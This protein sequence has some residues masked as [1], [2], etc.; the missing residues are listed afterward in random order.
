MAFIRK[1]GNHFCLVQSTRKGSKVRQRVIAYLGPSDSIREALAASERGLRDESA[2]RDSLRK[3]L[4]E[5]M[6]EP[7]YWMAKDRRHRFRDFRRSA[8]VNPIKRK[9]HGC[10]VRIRRYKKLIV[11]LQPYVAVASPVREPLHDPKE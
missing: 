3:E 5:W 10:N 11:R 1:K 7:E 8:I 9:I 4:R 2:A 6:R